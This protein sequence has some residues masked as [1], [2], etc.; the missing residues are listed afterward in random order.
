LLACWWSKGLKSSIFDKNIIFATLKPTNIVGFFIMKF[1]TKA[2]YGLRAIVHLDKKAE[3]PVSLAKIA[4]LE[5]ISLPY[6]ERLFSKLRK[7][8][9]VQANKGVKGGYYLTQTADKFNVYQI[10]RVLEGP[11][12]PYSCLDADKAGK[13]KCRIRPVW[14][15]LY[16]T[17]VKN[18]KSIKLSDL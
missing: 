8:G 4:R 14:E 13:C 16:K 15:K 17:I 1:S 6:L 18:L 9:I 2:E 7:A 5:K 10:I 3:K 12:V 11:V